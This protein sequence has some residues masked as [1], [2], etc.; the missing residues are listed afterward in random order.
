MEDKNGGGG[1]GDRI[2]KEEE[3]V[4]SERSE[5]FPKGNVTNNSANGYIAE[6]GTTNT[7][8]FET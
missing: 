6:G 8:R 3:R 7:S 5:E 4:R 2:A 1:S